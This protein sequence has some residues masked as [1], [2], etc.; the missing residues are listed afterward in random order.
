M[1]EMKKFT[2]YD[3]LDMLRIL[4]RKAEFDLDVAV[5]M[6]DQD[7]LIR[8]FIVIDHLDTLI[9]ETQDLII[10]ERLNDPNEEWV[11]SDDEEKEDLGF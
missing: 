6:R 10:D 11:D 7:K 3:I 5:K 4:K 8:M 2:N 9:D 1:S